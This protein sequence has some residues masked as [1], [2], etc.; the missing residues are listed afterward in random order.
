MHSALDV[1]RW[2]IEY[3]PFLHCYRHGYKDNH[4]KIEKL[5]HYSNVIMYLLNDEP[6]FRENV[7]AYREGFVV[8]EFYNEYMN[9]ERSFYQLPLVDFEPRE[10]EA[11]KITNILFGYMTGIELSNSVHID[12]IWEKYEDDSQEYGKPHVP[13]RKTD[14]VSYYK[15]QELFIEDINY[16][17]S[18]LGSKTNELNNI[19]VYKYGMNDLYFFFERDLQINHEIKE[20]MEQISRELGDVCETKYIYIYREKDGALY[21]E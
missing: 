16:I 10:L 15:N 4:L 17:R 8:E 13:L 2:F 3:N 12:D 7:V 11:L 18:N 20:L 9:H 19:E 5:L 1:A 6:I 14:I 21:V